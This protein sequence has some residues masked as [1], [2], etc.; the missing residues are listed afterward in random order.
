MLSTLLYLLLY[1]KCLSVVSLALCYV[2]YITKA[3][4]N[5][6]NAI[7]IIFCMITLFIT[8]FPS[9]YNQ[10]CTFYVLLSDVIK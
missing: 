9:S 5:P 7:K 6:D 2:C 10:R 8:L 1:I 4:Y 3:K